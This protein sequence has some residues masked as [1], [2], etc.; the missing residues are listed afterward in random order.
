MRLI[1]KRLNMADCKIIVDGNSLTIW[2]GVNLQDKIKANLLTS[3]ATCV[4]FGVG[5]QTT[6]QM[7][8]DQQ[9]QIIAAFDPAKT[10]IVVALELGN[11]IA[12][13]GITGAVAHSSYK[14]YGQAIRAA[15]G[16]FVAC[17]AFD[18]NSAANPNPAVRTG[19]NIAN[20]LMRDQW[21]GYANA[22]VD[23]QKWLPAVF[24]NADNRGYWADGIHYDNVAYDLF[25]EYCAETI[26]K[27]CS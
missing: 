16:K 1:S 15:G 23:A 17:T 9:S 21:P 24:D 20:N 8:S 25:A 2:G 14:Q 22:M 27:L 11:H 4:G 19:I 13:G 6:A 7:I 26:A 3:A 10:N 18:R 12:L 5:G